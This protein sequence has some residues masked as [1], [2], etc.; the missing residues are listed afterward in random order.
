MAANEL[1]IDDKFIKKNKVAKQ[2]DGRNTF[3]TPNAIGLK[4]R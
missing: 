2:R 4:P 3:I 1:K